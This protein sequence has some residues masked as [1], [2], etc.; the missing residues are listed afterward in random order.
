MATLKPNWEMSQ[1]THSSDRCFLVDSQD[2]VQKANHLKSVN[3]C[4][5]SSCTPPGKPTCSTTSLKYLHTNAPSTGN[6]QETV[7]IRV[8]SQGHDLIAV[9]ETWWDSWHD[10]NAVI[11]GCVPFRKDRPADEVV[12]LFSM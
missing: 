3:G 7:E 12:E 1:A 2:E 6:E 9:T 8:W 10:W 5:G 4:G 11:D